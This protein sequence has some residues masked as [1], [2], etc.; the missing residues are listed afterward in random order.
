MKGNRAAESLLG[1]KMDGEP[2]HLRSKNIAVLAARNIFLSFRRDRKPAF[3]IRT[4]RLDDIE[5]M[6]EL[7]SSEHSNRLFGLVTDRDRFAAGLNT[8]PGFSIDNYYVVEQG[9]RLIGVC[10]AWDTGAFKQNR[11][12]RYGPWLSAVR[13]G[14]NL[15][16]F[17][18]GTPA[19]PAPGEAFR[20]IFVTDWAVRDRS[21]E[22][23]H[24]LLEHVYSA[25]YGRGYHFMTFGSCADD[26]MLAATRGFSGTNVASNIALFSLGKRGLEPGAI[27]TSLPFIDIALL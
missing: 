27:N 21:V 10:A 11:V 19:L 25:F 18:A 20:S 5:G 24:A 1:D 13:A 23:M 9:R 22:V 4:A 17:F 26:P 8:R 7:L 3:A 15:I 6:V 2:W 14:N 12:V 16:S